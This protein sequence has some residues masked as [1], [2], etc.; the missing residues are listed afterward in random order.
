MKKWQQNLNSPCLDTNF[1]CIRVCFHLKRR[2]DWSC[3][4]CFLGTFPLKTQICHPPPISYP[5]RSFSRRQ[6]TIFFHGHPVPN[7]VWSTSSS[8][9]RCELNPFPALGMLVSVVALV[10]ELFPFTYLMSYSDELLS[11]V[12]IIYSVQPRAENNCPSISG[13]PRLAL[14]PFF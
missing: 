3:T 7:R 14:G 5:G 1:I 12:S 8:L 11:W 13:W 6:E 9:L 2:G 10:I 4:S